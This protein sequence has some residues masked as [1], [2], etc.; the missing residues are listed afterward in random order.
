[1][2]GHGVTS[3]GAQT[4]QRC[5][6]GHNPG[7]PNILRKRVRRGALHF[8]CDFRWATEKSITKIV[9]GALFS[10]AEPATYLQ[11]HPGINR[12]TATVHRLDCLCHR[13]KKAKAGPCL[14]QARSARRRWRV[15]KATASSRA[16]PGG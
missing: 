7:S 16:T 11:V 1:M 4:E 15:V 6:C 3:K 13:E 12:R 2:I 9:V 14:R 10:A 5:G 8:S